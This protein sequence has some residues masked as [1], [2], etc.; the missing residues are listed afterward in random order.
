M[1]SRSYRD[2]PFCLVT[3]KEIEL[4]DESLETKINSAMKNVNNKPE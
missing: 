4:V 1:E 2:Y 3:V